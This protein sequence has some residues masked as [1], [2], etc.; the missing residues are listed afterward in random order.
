MPDDGKMAP[1]VF[2]LRARIED[3]GNRA[4]GLKLVPIAGVSADATAVYILDDHT[5]P[6]VV[7]TD[8]NGTC[9][10]INPLLVPTTEPPTQGDQ[11]LK[12]RLVAVP[13]AGRADYT[14]ASDSA[15]PGVCLAGRDLEIPPPLCL[16][17]QPTIAIGYAFT[18]PAIWGVDEVD[19][20][21][22]LGGQFDALANN[23][24][25]GWACIAV[26]T[27]DKNGNFSVS[28]PLRVYIQY[29][30]VGQPDRDPPASAGPPPSCT[31]IYN[32]TD[33]TVAGGSCT[34]RKFAPGGICYKGFDCN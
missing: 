17:T 23:I 14:P 11:V 15:V 31:G 24:A 12:V 5:Q 19:G 3:D 25:E 7:D 16:G 22:C 30:G 6:L 4:E 2:D 33:N 29:R 26:G 27:T 21:H 34:A 32:R 10:S 18:Q 28:A 9:D 1:Q 20:A 8:G 13:P